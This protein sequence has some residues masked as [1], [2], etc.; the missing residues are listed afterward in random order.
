M[1]NAAAS[2]ASNLKWLMQLYFAK[3]NLENLNLLFPIYNSIF[4]Q[5]LSHVC[6]N[7]NYLYGAI[8]LKDELT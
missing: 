2:F 5:F 4:I 7:P 3:E 8:M 6:P 1:F